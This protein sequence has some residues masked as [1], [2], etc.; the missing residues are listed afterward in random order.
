MKTNHSISYIGKFMQSLRRMFK[1][2][3]TEVRYNPV[4][5]KWD[6]HFDRYPRAFGS[7]SMIYHLTPAD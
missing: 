5:A 3:A 2:A 1:P 6:E 4:M 7:R